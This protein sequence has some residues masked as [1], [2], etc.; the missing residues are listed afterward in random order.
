[1]RIGSAS[2]LL[3]L[4]FGCTAS[5]RTKPVERIELRL[6]GWSGLDVE[7][8]RQG[9]GRYRLSEPFPDGRTGAFQITA[10]QF[11]GLVDR[12]AEYRRRAVP[13]TDQSAREFM[14]RR[15]PDRTHFVTDR[16]A[17]WVRWSGPNTDK[18][19]MADLGCDP[20]RNAARNE[21]LISILRSLPVPVDH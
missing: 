18:H 11:T 4:L 7:V 13:M 1:M 21:N 12:L 19:Y 6:S 8:N 16:G 17:V 2:L 10:Q 20:E 15:C 9:E 5:E 14:K 3:A